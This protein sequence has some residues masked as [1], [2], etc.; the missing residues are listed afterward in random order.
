MSNDRIQHALSTYFDYVSSTPH[1][2]Q[3]QSTVSKIMKG[4]VSHC[5][6]C[7]IVPKGVEFTGPDF[8]KFINRIELSLERLKAADERSYHY[9]I[10]RYGLGM[11]VNKIGEALDCSKSTCTRLNKTALGFIKLGA[12]E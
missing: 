5:V 8:L 9:L 3:K 1:S 11:R 2:Y 10:M 4:E 6:A 7:S 12:T